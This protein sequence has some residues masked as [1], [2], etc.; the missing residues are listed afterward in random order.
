VN[1]GNS[2]ETTAWLKSPTASRVAPFIVFLGLTALQ[3]KLFP[4]SEYWIYFLKTI[5]GAWMLWVVCKPVSEARWKFSMEA[6]VAGIVVAILWIG[7]EGFYP[8]LEQL[9]EKLGW[10]SK[11]K[12]E[13][14]WNPLARF[15]AAP[16]LGWSFVLIRIVGSSLVVPPIEELF[17]RSFLYR[18]FIH[19]DF[20]KQPLGVFRLKPFLF[21]SVLF[22]L[23]HREWLPGILCG[24]I[25][26]GLVVRKG[27][28]GDAM[29]AHG[30]TNFLLGIWVVTQ[31][32]WK[33]W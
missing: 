21:T 25:Y 20:E 11:P 4:D 33:F 32:Q 31:G 2:S 13:T 27:R 19:P 16:M 3:G 17:Y 14:E 15:D 18:F 7:L 12:V 23:A 28:L 5:V 22:G 9:G 29:T 10:K 30:I 8:T 1:R 26:Q 6:I 24:F